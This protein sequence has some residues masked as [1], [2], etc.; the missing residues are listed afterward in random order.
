MVKFCLEKVKRKCFF[1]ILGHELEALQTCSSPML[2]AFQFE[3]S[4]TDF[5]TSETNSGN[6]AYDSGDETFSSLN[7]TYSTTSCS[8]KVGHS[9]MIFYDNILTCVLSKQ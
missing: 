7:I 9:G 6:W 5:C 3:L 8:V 1:S 4:S 2:G